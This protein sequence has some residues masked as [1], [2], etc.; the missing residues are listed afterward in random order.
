[1][2]HKF[3][4]SQIIGVVFVL[5]H[6]ICPLAFA[7]ERAKQEVKKIVRD[8]YSRTIGEERV[9]S[10]LDQIQQV[11]LNVLGS[12]ASGNQVLVTLG[13][14]TYAFENVKLTGKVFSGEVQ[15]TNS[16]GE[17]VGDFQINKLTKDA[18]KIV[19]DINAKTPAEDWKEVGVLAG[20]DDGSIIIGTIA[21]DDKPAS[22]LSLDI[23]ELAVGGQISASPLFSN[24]ASEGCPT[25]PT[26]FCSSEGDVAS[27]AGCA[28]IIAVVVIAVLIF[29]MF[30]NC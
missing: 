20:S 6:A 11:P 13:D 18:N 1:M 24:V 12:T 7:Q 19:Y 9:D 2:F 29:C 26:C 23:K 15:V 25:G 28:I 8:E 30:F 16:G 17:I 22:V 14:N 21:V 4:H 3:T 5:G 10:I 27:V